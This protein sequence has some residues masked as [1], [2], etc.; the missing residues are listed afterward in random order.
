MTIM[1]GQKT[2]GYKK[3]TVKFYLAALFI[4]IIDPFF[5]KKANSLKE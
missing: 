3:I 5:L 2:F 1:Y 4:I